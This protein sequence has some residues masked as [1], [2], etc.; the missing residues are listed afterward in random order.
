MTENDVF[1]YLQA[2]L[3]S[4]IQFVDPYLD[5]VPLPKGDYCQFNILDRRNIGWN[6][7]RQ[8]SFDDETGVV[9]DNY[10]IQ[11]IY[12][13]QIDFYGENAFDNAGLFNQILLNNIVDEDNYPVDLKR[14][15]DIQNRTFLAENKLYQKRY[16]FDIELFIVD[17]ITK[18]S[19]YIRAIQTETAIVG[20][21]N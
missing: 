5:D 2:L 12:T 4:T 14:I 13:V 18:D 10:D 3:P 16:G 19:P 6:Q 11:R 17:T 20:K 9:S 7:R 1:D 8:S 15:G 21:G